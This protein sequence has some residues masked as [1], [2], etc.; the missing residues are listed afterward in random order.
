ML[1]KR[2]HWKLE[3]GLSSLQA[4]LAPGSARTGAAN[5]AR[6]FASSVR[7]LA[8]AGAA[9][10]LFAAC[11]AR[12][13]PERM[14]S[15]GE[16][17]DL[18]GW[19]VTVHGFAVLPSHPVVQPRPGQVLCAVEVTLENAS[20]QIRYVMPERQMLLETEGRTF[21]LDRDASLLA[22]RLRQWI[23]PEGELS[24]NEIARG[25]ASYQIPLE[26]QDARWTFRS[27]LLPWSPRATFMLGSAAA[28]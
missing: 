19:R 8:L 20:G 17:A 9:A 23:V 24:V 25:A 22:A 5:G 3:N 14:Y 16:T 28:P 21:A 10:L 27:G 11:S 26:S 6:V 7:W 15:L 12:P 1:T 4:R 13:S 18:D 2:Y